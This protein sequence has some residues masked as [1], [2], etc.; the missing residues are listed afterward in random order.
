MRRAVSVDRYRKE[1]IPSASRSIDLH[2]HD[3]R[4]EAGC[5]WLEAGWPIHHVQE[6]LGHAN[7]SQT[8]TYLHAAEMGLQES[9]Q[10]F[11][12]SR[13]KSV[14]NGE[15]IE[16]PTVNHVEDEKQPKSLLH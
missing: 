11:D 10:R 8:S 4:H 13:G 7:L 3:L 9:M 1:V 5:R 6:M 16:Q 2:S 14:V 12:A 15:Q